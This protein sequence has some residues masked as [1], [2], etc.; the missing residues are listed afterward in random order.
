M[1]DFNELFFCIVLYNNLLN[2][3]IEREMENKKGNIN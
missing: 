1:C 2:E 3:C